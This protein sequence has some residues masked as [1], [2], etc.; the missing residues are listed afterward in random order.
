MNI[1]QHVRAPAGA[2]A[3]STL[4]GWLYEPHE[5]AEVEGDVILLVSSDGLVH[6]VLPNARAPLV[7]V[8]RVEADMADVVQRIDDLADRAAGMD[9]AEAGD[10][11]EVL[12]RLRALADR[13][14]SLERAT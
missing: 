9:V 8:L 7:A 13:V 10:K 2:V 1:E 3:W 5:A 4:R 6:G 11:A 12:A 14:A